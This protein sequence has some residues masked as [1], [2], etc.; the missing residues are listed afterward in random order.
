MCLINTGT[1]RFLHECVLVFKLSPDN[2]KKSFFKLGIFSQVKITSMPKFVL[3]LVAF[4]PL[5]GLAQI[6]YPTARKTDTT[7]NYYGV[8]V[9]DP[10]RWLEDDNSEET[11]NWVQE[12]NKVTQAY[13]EKIPF[14]EKIKK[15]LT[16]FVELPKVWNTFPQGRILLL[17]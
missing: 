10:Y 13:L 1:R 4:L 5:I 2:N 15:R 14:R 7:D 8:S 16:A 6:Q 17:W 12:E 11:K 3:S 9:A